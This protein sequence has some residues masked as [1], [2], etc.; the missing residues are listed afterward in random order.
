MSRGIHCGKNRFGE[1]KKECQT[2]NFITTQPRQSIVSAFLDAKSGVFVLFVFGEKPLV[3]WRQ[4]YRRF[5]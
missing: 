2:Q 5:Y 4:I 1:P 3:E